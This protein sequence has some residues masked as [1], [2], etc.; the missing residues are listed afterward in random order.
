[1][2]ALTAWRKTQMR[3]LVSAGD[4]EMAGGAAMAANHRRQ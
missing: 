4:G 3:W 1:M 2:T